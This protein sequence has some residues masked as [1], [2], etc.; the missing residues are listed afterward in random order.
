MRPIWSQFLGRCRSHMS[1]YTFLILLQYVVAFTI[2]FLSTPHPSSLASEAYWLSTPSEVLYRD[3]HPKASS[4]SSDQ[5]S[6]QER[7]LLLTPLKDA[8]SH[9]RHHFALLHNL[10]YPHHLIDL[11]FIIGDSTDNTRSLLDAELDKIES[12]PRDEAFNSATIVLKDLGN[13]RSEEVSKRHGFGAQVERRKKLAIVRNTLL[14]KAL[15]PVR[16]NSFHLRLRCAWR[17]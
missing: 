12:G 6:K 14:Q 7:V 13:A 8:A 11:G 1:T 3:F 16:F 5:N 10:T 4:P 15:K 17:R 9:L 2:P